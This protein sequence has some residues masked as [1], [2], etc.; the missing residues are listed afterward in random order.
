MALAPPAQ[1]KVVN[2]PPCSTVVSRAPEPLPTCIQPRKRKLT[3]DAP[4]APEILVPVAAAEEDK[5]SEAEVE[6]ESRE[7]CE[8]LSFLSAL[9]RLVGAAGQGSRVRLWLQQPFPT[10]SCS[11]QS[12]VPSH[13]LLVLAVLTILHVI[14]LCQGPELPRCAR[15]PH[16]CPRCH[17]P[18]RCSEWA[19]GR[20]GAPAAGPGGWPGHQGSQREISARSG[21]DARKAGGEVECCPAG[22]AQPP[23]GETRVFPEALSTS[24]H[25]CAQGLRTRPKGRV[26]LSGQAKSRLLLLS[27]GAGYP[28]SCLDKAGART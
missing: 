3:A 15:P 4:G 7:E 18:R 8:W 23:P 11:L 26:A 13:L 12:L 20:A 22:Q 28:Q 24:G 25:C 5:D 6:V 17:S 9:C 27:L 14:Q 1:Q 10:C 21:Q 16:G 19:G 2:S